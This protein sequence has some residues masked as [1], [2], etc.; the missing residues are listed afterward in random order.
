MSPGWVW[1]VTSGAIA[2]AAIAPAAA[3][4]GTRG[5][6]GDPTRPL[7]TLGPPPMGPH[8]PSLPRVRD[9]LLVRAQIGLGTQRLVYDERGTH[10]M[11]G[12]GLGLV[13]AVGS[14][15]TPRWS[16][17]AELFRLRMTD[18]SHTV[19]SRD[20]PETDNLAID[21]VGLGGGFAYYVGGG[22]LYVAATLATARVQYDG[23]YSG[24]L[25]GVGP[26]LSLQVGQ[27]WWASG[28][29]SVG[30]AVRGFIGAA[31]KPRG[32]RVTDYRMV[33]ASLAVTVAYD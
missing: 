18:P 21:L 9:G 15:L 5:P 19:D 13:V 32:E 6:I 2:V 27:E 4:P 17:Y 11:R 8:A 12:T 20:L 10:V 1:I 30:V 3:Q 31:P 26:M 23:E 24:Q 25:S 29:G 14:A 7:P 33:G 16:L 28:S 22:D